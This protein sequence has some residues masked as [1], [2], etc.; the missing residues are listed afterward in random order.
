MHSL[1]LLFLFGEVFYEVFEE[2]IVMG[3][4]LKLGKFIMSKSICN[5]LLLK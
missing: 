5:K 4:W 2:L 1:I 3:L